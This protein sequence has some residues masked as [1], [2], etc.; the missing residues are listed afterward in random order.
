MQ[1]TLCWETHTDSDQIVI[2]TMERS[3]S[4]GGGGE[5]R[6]Q[7]LGKNQVGMEKIV[8]EQRLEGGMGRHAYT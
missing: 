4:G 2:N 3:Q 5:G 7:A 6:E 1:A 8:T